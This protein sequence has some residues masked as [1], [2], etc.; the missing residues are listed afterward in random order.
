MRVHLIKLIKI[1]DQIVSEL[2]GPPHPVTDVPIQ[3]Q[4]ACT[5][6]GR[7]TRALVQVKRW[8]D[9]GTVHLVTLKSD[10]TKFPISQCMIQTNQANS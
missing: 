3:P 10:Q 1:R 7:M 8:S 6:N 5:L 2:I 9:A 4:Q